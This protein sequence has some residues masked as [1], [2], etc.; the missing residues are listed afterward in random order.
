[1]QIA[2]LM[3]SVIISHPQAQRKNAN[4]FVLG[5]HV[6][7]GHPV[8]LK[9]TEKFVLVIIHSKEMDTCHVLNLPR[10]KSQNVELM[11][12]VHLNW[13]VLENDVRTLV[14]LAILAAVIKGVR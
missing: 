9:I 11:L 4:P 3:K 2:L 5:T 12:T 7:Q 6:L 10:L 14:E 13:L 8:L 1:M